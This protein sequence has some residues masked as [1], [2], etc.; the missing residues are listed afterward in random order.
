[1][2]G[3]S[4]RNKRRRER[5]RGGG[6]RSSRRVPWP[7]LWTDSIREFNTRGGGEEKEKEEKEEG[8]EGEKEEE[9]EAKRRMEEFKE[10][11]VASTLERFHSKLQHK[12]R[13]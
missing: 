9:G 4:R 1:M 2:Q 10:G 11:P 13:R 3:R 6:R 5:R 7:P 8:K 12:R